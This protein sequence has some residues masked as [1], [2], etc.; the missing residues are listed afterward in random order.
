MLH[1]ERLPKYVG[2]R[3][4]LAKKI[5]EKDSS[6]FH[7]KKGHFCHLKD[8]SVKKRTL[9]SWYFFTYKPSDFSYLEKDSSVF[10][11]D[12]SVHLIEFV[13]NYKIIENVTNEKTINFF[14]YLKF[15]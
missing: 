6:V 9:L 1:H 8:T 10:A 5:G 4:L 12:S 11:K 13:Q 14:L 2:K 3:T 7:K 15:R